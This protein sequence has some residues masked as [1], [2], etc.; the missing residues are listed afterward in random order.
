[1]IR[2]NPNLF[3]NYSF[4]RGLKRMAWIDY[5]NFE[6]AVNSA[7]HLSKSHL[8]GSDDLYRKGFT[9]IAAGYSQQAINTF[10][11]L[12]SLEPTSAEAYYGRGFTYY[13]LGDFEQSIRDL[14]QAIQLNSAFADSYVIR[15]L[16]YYQLGNN[17]KAIEDSTQAID[18]ESDNDNAYF[19]LHL[20]L[21]G[22]EDEQRLREKYPVG[23]C[24]GN[25]SWPT[26]GRSGG[27]GDSS[28]RGN[29]LSYSRRGV[30]FEKR[31]DKRGAILNLQKAATLFKSKGDSTRYQEMRSSIERLKRR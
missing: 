26:I 29:P 27:C 30:S 2:L 17:K 3:D 16:I 28:L 20:A 22:S 1:M 11:E 31:G 8:R 18:L 7:A 10:T 25:G 12:L 21:T 9:Q 6:D 15:G 13:R 14:T 23:E 19:V 24:G 5:E 4:G